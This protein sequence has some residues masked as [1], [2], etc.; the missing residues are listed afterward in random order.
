MPKFNAEQRT[1]LCAIG[2]FAEQIEDLEEVLCVAVAVLSSEATK[3]A[4]QDVRTELNDVSA[5][6]RALHDALTKLESAVEHE[7]TLAAR[8]AARNRI[9]FAS[10]ELTRKMG[11]DSAIAKALEHV[12]MCEPIVS[13]AIQRM[14]ATPTRRMTASP[15]PI[16]LISDALLR[17][18]GRYLWG[19]VGETTT[20]HVDQP[21][22]MNVVPSGS[23]T[24]D[25]WRVV[26]VCY[27]AM[28]R[29]NT[30]PERAI[31]AFLKWQRTE[32]NV[33]N[34]TEVPS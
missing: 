20:R 23:P 4:L 12:A 19:P 6:F 32:R 14:P 26:Q 3:P 8:V 5:A 27:A 10:C 34:K 11:A 7:P 2:L 1:E 15:Y 22:Q 29:S 25:F 24:S 28:N 33:R 31:K 30:E 17:G 13:L 9:D 18:F 21:K 16:K